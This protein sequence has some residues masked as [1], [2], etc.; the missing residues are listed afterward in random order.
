MSNDENKYGLVEDVSETEELTNEEL[1]EDEQVQDEEI[2]EAKARKEAEEK[3]D[4]E[5]EVKESDEDDEDEEEVKEDS[6]EDDD[7]DEKPVVEMPKTKAA[8]MASV[9]DMLKK[10]KK[11][12]AQKIYASVMKTM[13]SDEGDDEEEEKPVKEDVNVDHIDYSEDLESL[14]AEEATLS[15]GFQAKAGIIFEAA[16]KSKVG[17]E[18]DRLESEYV[19]NLEEEV[20]EIKSELVE[21]VDSYLNYVVSNWMSENEVAVTTGLRTE[22]AEDFMASLQSVFKEHYIEVPEGKV[23]LVDE[24]AEQV[25]ELEESLN[26]STEDNIALTESVS[27]LERAEI[28]RNASSGLAL[29]EA[30]KLASL[31]EDIDFDD[32]ESF[33][34]KVN[35]VKESYFRSE[36]QESVDEAQQLVGTDEAP[37]ELND[38]MARYTQAISKF[39]K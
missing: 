26:K 5:E 10:S 9:N 24:L 16:L 18:I 34:M 1:V 19:A 17:A 23:D 14:V 33:E 3:D 28:V 25:A 32:A 29:T 11:L 12:D 35:V 13:E 27:N 37:A 30:E 7:E 4:D 15:D 39:N 21:K 36:A 20:T 8:I 6:D 2:V 22:I 38:V 31:V